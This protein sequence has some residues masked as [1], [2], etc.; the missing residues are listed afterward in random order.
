MDTSAWRAVYVGKPE[1]RRAL[2]SMPQ[3]ETRWLFA[4]DASYFYCPRS[5]L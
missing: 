3:A 1:R 4:A 5:G 2:E